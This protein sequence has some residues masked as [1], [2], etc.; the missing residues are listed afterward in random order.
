MAKKI[1]LEGKAK[2]EHELLMSRLKRL[3]PSKK[4]VRG[5]RN[6]Q[7]ILDSF[8]VIEHYRGMHIRN[9]NDWK[10]RAYSHTAQ[11][12]D[13]F[14][15]AFIRYPLAPFWTEITKLPTG[16][17]FILWA[18][19]VGQGKSLYKHLEGQL[20]KKEVHFFL[21]APSG[22]KIQQAIWYGKC[23]AAGLSITLTQEFIKRVRNTMRIDDKFWNDALSFM[24]RFQKKI[25]RHI[26]V[27]LV[28]YL[29]IQHE[30]NPKFTIR[31]QTLKSIMKHV[32]EWHTMRQRY[33]VP[34][35]TTWNPFPHKNSNYTSNR[36]EWSI[37][38]LTMARDLYAEAEIMKHCVGSYARACMEGR[39]AIY[40][41]ASRPQNSYD[42]FHK[43]VTIEVYAPSESIHHEYTITQCRGVCN[44]LVSKEEM[45]IIKRWA[46]E[47]GILF[48]RY[49]I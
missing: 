17:P 19:I 37:K 42:T 27:D 39:K 22:L 41:L 29:K 33:T 31:K 38:Q 16:S 13:L 43:A 34:P 26:M 4:I 44:R 36:I 25:D 2:E 7:D 49:S 11:Q 47:N 8:P 32:V 28:D 12:M 46:A 21:N 45:D 15:Y 9:I 14:N 10:S 3:S 48:G 40:S 23:T 18:I 5:K 35:A 6:L 30:E 1:V 24:A 20:T